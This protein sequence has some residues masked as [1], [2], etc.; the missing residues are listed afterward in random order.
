MEG[1]VAGK[2]I[3]D[4]E[5]N[6]RITP[7]ARSRSLCVAGTLLFLFCFFPSTR[8]APQSRKP[9]PSSRGA[10]MPTQIPADAA[11]HFDAAKIAEAREDWRTAENEYHEALK[12]SPDWP[13]AIVN[14]GIVYNR[15]GKTDEAIVAF[16]RAAELNPQLL[17][18]QLNLAITYFRAQR[19]REAETPLRRTLAIDPANKQAG[20]LL[21]FSLFA[22]DR[23]AEVIELGE[24]LVAGRAYDAAM[25]ELV[26]RAFLKLRRYD[27][28]VSALESRAKL[29]PVSAEIYLLLGEA[30][31]NAG[32]SEGAIQEFNRAIAATGS[33]PLPELHF[34][35]GYVLWK[36]R[37]YDSAE[38]AFRRELERDPNHARSVYYLGNIALSRGDWK[39]ALLLLER[40][41]GAMPRDFQARY[42]FGKALIQARQVARAVDEL[43]A[44]IALNAKN[45]GAHYQLALAYRQLKREDEAQRELTLAG[46]L[47]KAERE[48]LEQKVQGEERKK[49]P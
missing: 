47:N 48:D 9:E 43:R 31:D 2:Q 36:L 3:A 21:V 29:P 27:K 39:G 24:K 15:Q 30:R 16:T 49:K 41:A 40:A 26:G 10:S 20:E 5:K 42:D 32:D 34:A 28:A 17:G 38:T 37:R 1:K 12:R 19:F 13:E 46:E 23:Y 4:A 18:A 25:L 33:S 35:L 22:Q 44:A 6:G 11:R 7:V 45:S 8:A 14:L